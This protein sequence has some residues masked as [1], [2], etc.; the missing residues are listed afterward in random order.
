MV[1]VRLNIPKPGKVIL[2]S[3]RIT[4]V[5]VEKKIRVKKVTATPRF[6]VGR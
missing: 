3:P 5:V 1:K 4:P 6:R 2:P